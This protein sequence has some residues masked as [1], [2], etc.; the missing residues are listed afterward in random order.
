MVFENEKALLKKKTKKLW[1][2]IC[3][4]VYNLYSFVL[5]QHGYLANTGSVLIPK[6]VLQG[7]CG[8]QG[9]QPSFSCLT[10][11]TGGYL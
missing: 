10:L 3:L 5:I 9:K 1:M 7:G 11:K 6:T 4:L 8:I 2:V